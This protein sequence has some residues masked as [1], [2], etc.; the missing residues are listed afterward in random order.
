MQHI[1]CVDICLAFFVI[2][3]IGILYSTVFKYPLASRYRIPE[4]PGHLCNGWAEYESYVGNKTNTTNAKLSLADLL[5]LKGIF[6]SIVCINTAS[7]SNSYSF[8]KNK[9]IY[10]PSSTVQCKGSVHC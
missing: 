4:H 1:F 2:Y 5:T 10:F 3:F 9:N 6:V 7:P 8:K